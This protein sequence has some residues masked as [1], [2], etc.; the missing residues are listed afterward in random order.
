MLQTL[1]VGGTVP[2]DT[3][4]EAWK[5]AQPMDIRLTGQV[6]APPRWQNP[7][8]E[9]ATIQAIAND[10]E[11]AFKLTWDDPFKDVKHDPEKELNA[12]E[13]QKVGLYSSYVSANDTIPR[14]LETFR[15]SIALQ[16]PVKTPSGTQK[17]HFFRGESSRQVN[18]WIWNADLA[19]QGKEATIEA[20]ARG[21]RQ[22]PK[23]QKPDQRQVVSKVNWDQ[24]QWTLVMKRP[25]VTDDKNDV[26][27]EAG[28]FIPLTLNAW[29]GSNG[30]HGLIM[31]LSTWH[32]VL[33]E[34]PMPVSVYI[35]TALGFLI[36][37][38]LLFWLARKAEAAPESEKT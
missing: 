34:A 20:N 32:Y 10:T 33:I 17:P 14:A 9:M 16:F 38:G 23:S 7:S 31:S 36:T 2:D 35:F 5:A 19:E 21:W 11:I 27:F 37:G 24:G 12:A 1:T 26:Q 4:D 22:N 30:E 3:A 6:I 18:L 8:I 15:D 29:D 25:L 13:I 28:K